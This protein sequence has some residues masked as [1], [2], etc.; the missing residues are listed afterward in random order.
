MA[1][2]RHGSRFGPTRGELKFRLAVSVAG[3]A[4]M[5]FAL[6]YRGIPTGPAFVEVVGLA[7]LF[8][9]GTA[10]WTARR[11]LRTPRDGTGD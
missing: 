8:F 11:L 7:G 4:L 6:F 3:L 5:V 10:I 2:D 1:D 9:G